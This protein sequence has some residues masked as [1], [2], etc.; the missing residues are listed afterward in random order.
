MLDTKEVVRGIYHEI[1]NRGKCGHY[2]PDEYEKQC[3]YD[4][5]RLCIIHW[6]ADALALLK[7][8]AEKQEPMLCVDIVSTAISGMGKCPQCRVILSTGFMPEQLHTKFCY[9][10]GQAVKWE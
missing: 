6:G 5:D 3:P 8:L 4:P 10:C 9:N 7:S 2:C 1:T